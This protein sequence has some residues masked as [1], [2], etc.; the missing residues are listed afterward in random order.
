[1]ERLGCVRYE[2]LQG[3]VVIDFFLALLSAVRVF[4]RSRANTAL[5]LIALRQQL[6]VFKLWF[7]QIRSVPGLPTKSIGNSQRIS[8]YLLCQ[9]GP[10]PLVHYG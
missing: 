2:V 7:S 6:A 4:F 10:K 3:S 8:T 9:R 1:V 5:E